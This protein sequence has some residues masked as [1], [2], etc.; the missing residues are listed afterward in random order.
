MLFSRRIISVGRLHIGY[1]PAQHVIALGVWEGALLNLLEPAAHLCGIG[2]T[3]ARN[4]RPW[5]RQRSPPT[6]AWA[7][8]GRTYARASR[9][10]V[11]TTCQRRESSIMFRQWL[12]GARGQGGAL[13][14]RVGNCNR[15][16][17]ASLKSTQPYLGAVQDEQR[18]YGP[19]ARGMVARGPTYRDD[20][21][22]RSA[23]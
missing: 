20:G 1:S 18:H 13:G 15:R 11:A 8:G 16:T 9:A 19:C 7:E 17:R 10:G 6:P 23:D 4:S 5:R 14:G 22:T 12:S 2:A 21:Q 3:R